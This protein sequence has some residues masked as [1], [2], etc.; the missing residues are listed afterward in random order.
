MSTTV[1]VLGAHPDD[2]D[3]GIGGIIAKLAGRGDK[4]CMADLTAGEM[5]SR[6]TLEERQQ[7]AQEAAQRLGAQSRDCL[8]LPDSQLANVPEQRLRVL[9]CIRRV[10]PTYIFAPM[11]P[12]RHPDHCAA[13]ELARDANF[14]AGLH[15]IQTDAPP[16]R[17]GRLFYYHPYHSTQS[18]PTLVVDI[19]AVYEQKIHALKAFTSQFHNPGYQGAVTYIASQAFWEDIEIRARF[20]GQ[21]IGVEYGEPLYTDLPLGVDVP[22]QP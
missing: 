16:H 21:R 14:M 20:W 1:L 7:E 10:R 4:I 9:A 12:D 8:G 3:L 15:K 13:H 19:S 18:A 22:W 2:A 6:G 11:T 17:A 5:G